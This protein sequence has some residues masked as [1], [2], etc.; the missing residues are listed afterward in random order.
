MRGGE[1]TCESSASGKGQKS[2]RLNL[3]IL[4][5]IIADKGWTQNAFVL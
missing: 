4:R 3:L 1:R 5:F 2:S